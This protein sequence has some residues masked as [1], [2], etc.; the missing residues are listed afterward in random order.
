M[1]LVVLIIL[2]YWALASDRL[3]SVS[4]FVYHHGKLFG[5]NEQSENSLRAESHQLHSLCWKD[6]LTS[7]PR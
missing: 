5:N 1:S 6:A 7:P 2:P 3:R 4:T